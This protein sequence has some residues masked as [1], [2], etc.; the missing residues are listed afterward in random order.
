MAKAYLLYVVPIQFILNVIEMLYADLQSE[1]LVL[2]M[3]IHVTS[4]NSTVLVSPNAP[5]QNKAIIFVI[6]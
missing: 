3:T 4:V 6:I 1:D 5:Q 2:H